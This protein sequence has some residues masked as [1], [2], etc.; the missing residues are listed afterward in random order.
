MNRRIKVLLTILFSFSFSFTLI[1][2]NRFFTDA[3]ANLVFK[4]SGK[5]EITPEKYRSSILDNQAMKNFL[6][7][8]PSEKNIANKNQAPVLELPMPDGSIAKFHIWESP[9][10]EPG[11]AAKYPEIKTF[12]GQGIDDP[13]ATVRL[14][15]NP[16]FGFTAQI[17]SVNGDTY[18]DPYAKGDIN[19]YTSYYA[20]DNKRNPVFICNTPQSTSPNAGIGLRTEAA[21]RGAQL[22]TYR[23]ALAC[24]G[25]YAVAVCSPN[26]AT[27]PATLAAMVTSVNRVDGVYESELSIK[28]VLVANTDQLIY[29][30]GT[31]DPYTNNNGSVMLGQNQANVDAI[32]GTSNYDF[33]HVF[34]TGGGGIAALGVICVAGSKAEGVT[35]LPNPVGDN[36]D[37]D[38][39]AHE[40]GHE[41]GANHPF[42]SSTGNC[43]GGNRNPG[44]AYEVGSGTTIMAYAGI[45]SSDDIQPHSDPFF[46]GISFDEIS[47]YLAST[48][49]GCA[50]ITNT[51][52]NIPVITSMSNNGTNIPASTPFTLSATA[53][54][55]D[56]DPLTYDW[57]EWDL[58]SSTA[59]NGG[60]TNTT[61]PL[62]KSRRPKMSGSR[63]FPDS[64]LILANYALS[65]ND[66]NGFVMD[67]NKGETLPTGSRTMNFKLTVRDNRAGGG[68][69]TSGGTGGC[70]TGFTAPFSIHVV[71]GTGPFVLTSPN[72]GE[73]IIGGSTITITWNVAGT[74]ASPISAADVK[75]SL[76][77]DGGL[78]YPTVLTA[79]TANNGSASVTIPNTPTSTARIKIEPVGNI[80]FDVSDA[81][82]SILNPGAPFINTQPRSAAT[83]V[84][85]NTTFSISAAGLNLTY[86]WQR[87]TANGIFEDILS[88]NSNTYTE[89]SITLSMNNYQYR[90]IVT[91]SVAPPDTSNAAVLTVI[92][93]V[94]ITTQPSNAS[95][96]AA[97]PLTSGNVSFTVAG[98]STQ[99]INYQWQVSTDGGTTFN[100]INIAAGKIATLALSGVDISLNNNQYRCLLSNA[101]C[102]TPTVSSPAT[103]T[104]Y[105]LPTV[106]LSASPYTHLF[107]GLTT[108]LTATPT[109]AIG[110]DLTWYKNS[111]LIAGQTSN[112]LLV[113][114]SGLGNYQVIVSD[115]NGCSSNSPV[116][117]IADS[118]S[119]KL[120]IYPNPNL[121]QFTVAYYNPGGINTQQMITI[122]DSHGAKVYNGTFAVSSP[123]QLLSIDMKIPARGIYYVVVGN[124]S[125]KKLAEGKLLIH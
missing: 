4:T 124:A 76:S 86:Q 84:G 96:C 64:S 44:T 80:F 52:N 115:N 47:N 29:L 106:N 57:E 17:L 120:F 92:A 73:D 121:G 117:T 81:N 72:G 118:A 95:V 54:D 107:P 7:S 87:D 56:G 9:V 23:L 66:L 112:S 26:P 77:T 1:A 22:Y 97:G 41:F 79:S 102:T 32:I 45:C 65:S 11:L 63:T 15:Y 42:N 20:R 13:Y 37:I 94:T 74:D 119:S 53:T 60:N 35:G 104:V 49:G 109:P 82:F 116:V 51:G 48:G 100:N 123:Y 67:G 99:T 38:Y 83:C 27:V 69:V 36:F 34:S 5:R 110:T 28:M 108:T 122:F 68:G 113:D 10:M 70:Q 103:L 58:G 30:D 2:Q 16:Y 90:C 40:M 12:E 88:A 39:V 50:V 78:T 89:N 14:G 24:T 105:S 3:G 8:L 6:W 71:G 33:G 18:I 43:G 85:S 75:V 61:S 62:F 101:T 93:P 19:Y 46:H 21:C 25:E 114:V 98:N 91:G 111:N 125:G 55:A 59:W 31:T